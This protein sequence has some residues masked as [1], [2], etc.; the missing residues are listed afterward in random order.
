MATM[1]TQEQIREEI[2]RLLEEDRLEEAEA[3][4]DQLIPIDAEEFKKRLDAAPYDDEPLSE[5]QIEAS[6]RAWAIIR[7]TRTTPAVRSAG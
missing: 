6:E 2:D 7:G 4:V 5:A 3:L 1:K